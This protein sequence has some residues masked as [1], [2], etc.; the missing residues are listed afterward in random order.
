ME[1]EWYMPSKL[2]WKKLRLYPV[3]PTEPLRKTKVAIAEI[4]LRVFICSKMF[5]Y[6]SFIS[7][8]KID[9]MVGKLVG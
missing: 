7:D 3:S 1:I 5:R 9:K 6:K 4:T 2:R 8:I